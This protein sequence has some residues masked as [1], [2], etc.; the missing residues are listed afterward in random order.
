MVDPMSL[1][2]KVCF[3]KYDRWDEINFPKGDFGESVP[4]FGEIALNHTIVYVDKVLYS[5]RKH[6]GQI[7]SDDSKRTNLQEKIDRIWKEKVLRKPGY[8]KMFSKARM[9][10]KYRLP[11]YYF[12][13]GHLKHE[14][15]FRPL[16]AI[17]KIFVYSLK[18]LLSL[19]FFLDE[20]RNLNT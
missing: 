7:T 2:K 14:L 9:F 10:S 15:R 18:W 20:K 13:N 19:P 6:S 11:L 16:S 17:W 3:F 12:L 8:K 4:L 5:Y 1:L